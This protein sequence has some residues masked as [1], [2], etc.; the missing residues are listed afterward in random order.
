[1]LESTA[2]QTG[3]VLPM[4]K[5]ISVGVVLAGL[6]GAHVVCPSCGG[7]GEFLLGYYL[8]RELMQ[9]GTQTRIW[10][11]TVRDTAGAALAGYQ[12]EIMADRPDPAADEKRYAETDSEGKY[13]IIMPW[14]ELAVYEITVRHQNMVVYHEKVGPVFNQ[15]QHRE[16]EVSPVATVTVSGT[17]VDAEAEP[18]AQVF[19]AVARPATAGTEPDT[20]ATT[21]EG[22]LNYQLT[23][24]TGVYY[25]ADIFGEPLLVAAF[26]PSHGFGYYYLQAPSPI[27]SGGTIEMPGAGEVAV[28]IRLLNSAGEPLGSAVLPVDYRFVL[29]ATPAYDLSSLI[30]S[31][32]SGAGLFSNITAEE[33]IALHPVEQTVEV[34]SSNADSLA[35]HTLRLRAGL[36]RLSLEDLAGGTYVGVLIG[37]STRLLD[38]TGAGE[39]VEV[40]IPL[41]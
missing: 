3:E 16:I 8:Y 32:V 13:R 31:A 34:Q 25:F 36:Y 11:G 20:F 6:L 26:H 27:N 15:D 41:S 7:G 19:V 1:M 29:R 38:D 22:E 33:V 18:L 40:R 17:V 12:V 5:L 35:E 24:N 9:G 37:Q 23:N 14:Y 30:G 4:R 2:V 28:S 10:Q 39:L 21:A